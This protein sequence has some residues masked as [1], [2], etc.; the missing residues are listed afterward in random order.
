MVIVTVWITSAI[1]S[2]PKFLFAKTIEN[3]FSD[4]KTEIFCALDRQMFNSK[5]LDLINFGLLY[6]TPLLVMTVSKI[7][8]YL[9]I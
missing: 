2:T 1:Y 5:L 3:H 9:G 8:Y 7:N 4:G 6:I